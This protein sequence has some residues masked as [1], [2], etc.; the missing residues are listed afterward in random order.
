MYLYRARN[1]NFRILQ[2]YKGTQNTH[3]LSQSVAGDPKYRTQY[4][5]P[6]FKADAAF[7]CIA[8]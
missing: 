1:V 4:P 6:K 5:I 8:I 2:F 7:L 3:Y